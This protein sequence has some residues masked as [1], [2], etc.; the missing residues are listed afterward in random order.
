[1]WKLR[2]NA[3]RPYYDASAPANAISLPTSYSAFTRLQFTGFK[4]CFALTYNVLALLLWVGTTMHKQ[5]SEIYA[6]SGRSHSRIMRALVIFHLDGKQCAYALCTIVLKM[7]RPSL[8]A[9]K[10]SLTEL[11]HCST[12]CSLADATNPTRWL[13]LSMSTSPRNFENRLQ[14]RGCGRSEEREEKDLVGLF[15]GKSDSGTW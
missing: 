1:M 7:S 12:R 9:E 13:G 2:L 8:V 4:R 10:N 5:R 15:G 3:S 14:K 6:A 11:H